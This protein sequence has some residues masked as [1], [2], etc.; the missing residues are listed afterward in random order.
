M[1]IFHFMTFILFLS[2]IAFFL[3]FN[4]GF[5]FKRLKRRSII[6]KMTINE[7]DDA[8]IKK[9]QK[10]LKYDAELNIL[11][12]ES[13]KWSFMYNLSMWTS[14]ISMLSCIT[15]LK[16]SDSGKNRIQV[17]PSIYREIVPISMWIFLF[18]F[19]VGIIIA[20]K[21]EK[22]NEKHYREY[23]KQFKS[24]IFTPIFSSIDSNIY[25]EFNSFKIINEENKKD[26]SYPVKMKNRFESIN[27]N[28]LQKN[29]TE[30]DLRYKNN[31]SYINYDDY[32]M[33]M[34]KKDFSIEFI[35]YRKYI[36]G[37]RGGNFLIEEGVYSQSKF[38]KH[39]RTGIRI[40]TNRIIQNKEADGLDGKFEVSVLNGEKI[41]NLL[42]DK[43][44]NYLKEFIKKSN[45]K[46]DIIIID[47]EINF[48]FKTIDFLEPR[49]VG[50]IIDEIMLK[51]YIN[52]IKFVVGFSKCIHE[53]LVY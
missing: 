28:K 16:V 5:W 42:S 49:L 18:I 15:I 8:N 25:W 14:L 41:K 21:T 37:N 26:L 34:Y 17:A 27:F 45:L 50:N 13:F 40:S 20:L 53:D 11:K 51:E 3:F 24:K 33:G 29:D 39:F 2:F 48:K 36:K 32:L 10:E 38:N 44:L 12:R 30:I 23:K 1:I 4:A 9:L 46:F 7:I 52:I 22:V 47:N 6:K 35:E 43:T 31:S 19:V